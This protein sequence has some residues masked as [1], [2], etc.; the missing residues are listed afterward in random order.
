MTLC[1]AVMAS[2]RQC[3]RTGSFSLCPLGGGDQW[4]AEDPV[5]SGG[6]VGLVVGRP[7]LSYGDGVF[8]PDRCGQCHFGALCEAETGRCVCP[9]NVWPQ[10]SLCVALSGRICQ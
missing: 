3:V 2:R 8:S 6:S 7:S 1:V 9:P 5:V 4:L 10:P